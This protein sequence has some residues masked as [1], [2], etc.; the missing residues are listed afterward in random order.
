MFFF[1]HI[2]TNVELTKLKLLH[3]LFIFL[4]L[5]MY[6]K[7]VWHFCINRLPLLIINHFVMNCCSVKIISL[8][9]SVIQIFTVFVSQFYTKKSMTHIGKKN[10]KLLLK[11]AC[12]LLISFCCCCC[13]CNHSWRS[14]SSLLHR[15]IS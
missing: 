8:R 3:Y 7:V 12:H 13:E 11:N 5:I 4:S 9:M 14:S 2:V 6:T 1:Y 15:N 10:S